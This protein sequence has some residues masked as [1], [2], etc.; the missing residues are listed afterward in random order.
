MYANMHSLQADAKE[1][2]SQ[3]EALEQ[4]FQVISALIKT[5]ILLVSVFI[6]ICLIT[7]FIG[8]ANICII[9]SISQEKFSMNDQERSRLVSAISCLSYWSLIQ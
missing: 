9:L 6:R 5:T 4:K 3:L 7:V 1:L 8:S 2:Q